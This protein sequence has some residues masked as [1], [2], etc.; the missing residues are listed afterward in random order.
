MKNSALFALLLL[1]P[2]F[3]VQS[4]AADA[5]SYVDGTIIQADGEAQTRVQNDFLTIDLTLER[6]DSDPARLHREVQKDAAG[7]LEKAHKVTAVQIKTSGYSVIPV[8]EKNRIVRQQ[9]SY[10]IT[11]ETRDF[12]A[13]LALA[14]AMQPF[15]ISNLAF[16]V[17]PERRK[18]TEKLL[19]QRAIAEMRE[20]FTIAA[21]SLGPR[22]VTITNITVGARQYEPIQHMLMKGRMT[23]QADTALPAEAGESQLTVTVSGTALAK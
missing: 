9:A 8:Y 19:I 16:S 14:G 2:V 10:R 12:D 18:D 1:N 23:A 11:I 3:A 7:A 4:H 5:P 6:Q 22:T 17:S 20:K 21:N 13:G 15:Q